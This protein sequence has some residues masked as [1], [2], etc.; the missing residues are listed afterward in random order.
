MN[1]FQKFLLAASRRY[2]RVAH[3]LQN[4]LMEKLKHE[5]LQPSP[6]IWRFAPLFALAWG[7]W[8]IDRIFAHI[9]WICRPR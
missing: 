6:R 8:L 1:F 5:Q 3:P 9:F 2:R 4:R 7:F